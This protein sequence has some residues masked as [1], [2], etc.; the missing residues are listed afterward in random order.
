[1]LVDTQLSG[2]H[3]VRLV[4]CVIPVIWARAGHVFVTDLK[5]DYVRVSTADQDLTAQREAL[6]ASGLDHKLTCTD[7][8]LTGTNRDRPSLREAPAARSP[9]PAGSMSAASSAVGRCHSG[10]TGMM[11]VPAQSWSR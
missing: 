1:M 7:H 2:R 8:C 6:V 4:R 9:Q 3:P 5:I 10:N 11:P